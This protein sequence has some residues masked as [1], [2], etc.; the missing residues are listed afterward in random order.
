MHIIHLYPPHI[1]ELAQHVTLLTELPGEKSVATDEVKTFLDLCA[2]NTPDIVHLHGCNQNEFIRA[3]LT[4]RQKGARIVLTPHGHLESWEMNARMKQP[5]RLKEMVRRAFCVIVRSDI[6]AKELQNLRWNT[7][8]EIIKNPIL[9]RTTDKDTCLQQHLMVYRT[10]MNSFVL[11]KFS[12]DSINALRTLLKVGINDDSRWGEP[13]DTNTVD[14]KRLLIYTHQEGVQS[15]FEKGCLLMGIR[16]PESTIA[17]SYLPDNYE[18]PAPI[19]GKTITEMVAIIKRQTSQRNLT[20][21]SLANLD[22]ALRRDDVADDRLMEQMEEEHLCS[23]FASLLTVMHEQTGL[24]EGF[25]P[26]PPTEDKQTKRIRTTIQ[27]H[28]QI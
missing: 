9:T 4:A 1:P 3:A 7:R 18:T 22:Q 23:F 28:L 26:C 14:W 16:Q 27:K 13:F 12:K 10:V 11:E 21:L 8:V 5:A 19:S 6:E 2:A 15:Y 24:D 25:M 20:L 17:P